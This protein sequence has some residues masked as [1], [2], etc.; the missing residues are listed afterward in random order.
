MTEGPSNAGTSMVEV[1]VTHNEEQT[2]EDISTSD[3]TSGD[4]TV[5]DPGKITAHKNECTVVVGSDHGN[6][7]QV[8]KNTKSIV[9]NFNMKGVVEKVSKNFSEYQKKVKL[10]GIDLKLHPVVTL[11]HIKADTPD[12]PCEP[13]KEAVVTTSLVPFH[14]ENSTQTV[15]RL[16]LTDSVNQDTGEP[17]KKV[18]IYLDEELLL[19]Q[20]L[21]QKARKPSPSKGK[22][23]SKYFKHLFFSDYIT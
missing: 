23:L 14:S 4:T 18:K 16:R 12:K 1:E 22:E 19:E 17:K 8:H 7:E 9:V 20:F 5:S 15:E 21:I 13:E 6:G 3:T 2:E 10:Q 11:P